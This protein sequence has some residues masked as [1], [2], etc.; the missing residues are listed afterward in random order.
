MAVV[1]ISISGVPVKDPVKKKDGVTELIFKIN[2]SDKENSSLYRVL[3]NKQIWNKALGDKKR[4]NYYII[5]GTTKASVTS[6]GNP[7]ITVNCTELNILFIENLDDKGKISLVEN[8]PI[9]TEEVVDISEIVIDTNLN[10]PYTAKGKVIKYF[11]KHK[12]F[13]NPIKVKRETKKLLSGYAEYIAAKE[14]GIDRVPVSYLDLNIKFIKEDYKE[15]FQNWSEE[16]KIQEVNTQDIVLVEEIHLNTLN[17]GFRLDLR[18][19]KESGQITSP[20]AVRP[21]ENGKYGVLIGVSKYFAAKILDIDKMPVVIKDMSREEFVNNL[22]EEAEIRNKKEKSDGKKSKIE[23]IDICLIN[24]PDSFAKT[25]PRREKI[26]DAIE[27]YNKHGEFDKPVAI[28]A[29]SYML[30]DGYKRYVAAKE[31]GLKSIKVL[32][33]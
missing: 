16:E 29:K 8:L 4:I 7:F 9:G 15:I 3:V 21:L 2:N 23:E 20:M 11:E 14:L 6:K 10:Y 28:K 18:Y 19:L 26:D 13:K 24:I 32:L 12:T 22:I 27:Y 1:K 30:K 31:L 17:L 33:V 25:K 5:K